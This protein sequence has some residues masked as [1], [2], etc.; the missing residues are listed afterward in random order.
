MRYSGIE[1]K[2]AN[3]MRCCNSC[4]AKNYDEEQKG[5]GKHVGRIITIQAGQTVISLCDECA[6]KLIV[7]L[8]E[9]ME[10]IRGKTAS[11]IQC[12]PFFS[13]PFNAACW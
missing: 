7:S 13:Y 12:P 2:I 5:V 1:I 11:M 10:R 6:R 3:D 8:G 9:L 4:Y